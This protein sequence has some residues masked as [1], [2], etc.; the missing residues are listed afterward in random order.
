MYQNARGE[1]ITL[2]LGALDR[3]GGGAAA[4]RRR[5]S[6]SPAKGRVPSF[7]WVDQ[8]FGYAL[9]GKLPRAACWRWPRRVYKQL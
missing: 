8:G 5:P 3:P 6:A 9:A 1:R 2:Y 7:Y 4:P